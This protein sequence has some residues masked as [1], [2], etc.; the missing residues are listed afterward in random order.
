MREIEDFLFRNADEQYRDFSKKLVPST[1]Y[2]IIGVRIPVL[3]KYAK[4]IAQ[5]E[6]LANAFLIENHHYFEEWFLHG[7]VIAQEKENINKYLSNISLFMSHIDNWSICDSVVAA[8]KIIKNHKDDVLETIRCWIQKNDT[9]TVRFAVVSLLNYFIE[10]KY[11][12]DI[13]TLTLS[14]DTQEYYVNMAISWLYSVMLVKSYDYTVKIFENKL[15]KNPFIH[16]TAIR[17]ARESLRINNEEKEYL[18]TL[19]R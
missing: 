3:K 10:K 16:N 17:K 11:L 5:N 7:L 2:K 12:D 1:S 15:I 6:R 13:L 8:S 19:V 18:K 14:I 4:L 9:Y